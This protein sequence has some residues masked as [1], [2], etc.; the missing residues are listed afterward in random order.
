VPTFWTRLSTCQ[1]TQTI[2]C[3]VPE[4]CNLHNHHCNN[5]KYHTLNLCGE[6]TLCNKFLQIK[7]VKAL[8]SLFFLQRCRKQSMV[9]MTY[10]SA[11][12]PK[13]SSELLVPIL[14]IIWHHN[15]ENHN[16]Q[17]IPLFEQVGIAHGSRLFRFPAKHHGCVSPPTFRQ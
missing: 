12:Y 6:A 2:H 14:Q 15:V 3:Y 5:L 9:H 8:S 17:N 1:T 13:C 4:D 7:K 10:N 16:P 11:S